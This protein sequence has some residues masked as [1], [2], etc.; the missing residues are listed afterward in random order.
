MGSR[1]N[2]FNKEEID[3][4]NRLKNALTITIYGSYYPESE[5]EFLAT[6]RNFLRNNGYLKT[7]LVTDYDNPSHLTPLDISISCLEYSDVNFLI[8]TRNGKNQGVIRELTHVAT[9]PTM[10]AKIPFCTVFDEIQDSRSSI[11]P[12]S[13]EDMRNSNIIRREF[14]SENQL[15]KILSQQAFAKTRIL[16]EELKKRL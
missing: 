8:F 2:K 13:L 12:L 3:K 14:Q 16:K 7:N 6:Q 11:S 4:F 5:L 9:S 15:Q 10:L 1:W